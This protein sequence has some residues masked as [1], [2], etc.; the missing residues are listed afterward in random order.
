MEKNIP[1][2]CPY[3]EIDSKD[4]VFVFCSVT[5]DYINTIYA[6]CI[7]REYEECVFYKANKANK[8]NKVKTL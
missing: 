2:D 7:S 5:E 8:A 3:A 6:S 1:K 4:L